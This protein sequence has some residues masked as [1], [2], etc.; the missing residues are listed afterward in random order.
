LTTIV[1]FTPHTNIQSPTLG[2]WLKQISGLISFHT[3][4]LTHTNGSTG[5]L[6]TAYDYEETTAQFF[7]RQFNESSESIF[8]SL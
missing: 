7:K 4:R 6:S 3:A 2:K 5:K 1:Q 8:K